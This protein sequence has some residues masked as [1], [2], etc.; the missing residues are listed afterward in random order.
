MLYTVWAILT[1]WL[2]GFSIVR[3]FLKRRYGYAALALGGGYL[4][5]FFV[6]ALAMHFYDSLAT[7]LDI[8]ALLLLAWVI[9]VALLIFAPAKRCSIE[10]LRLE[11]APPNWV[12]GVA[13]CLSL[14]LLYRWGLAL[15]DLLYDS[16]FMGLA[17][18]SAT[19]SSLTIAASP[20]VETRLEI[21]LWRFM[22]LILLSL[23]WSEQQISLIGSDFLGIGASVAVYLLVF[24]GLRYLGCQLLP[25]LLSA[26]ALVSFLSVGTEIEAS[27]AAMWAVLCLLLIV[28]GLAIVLIYG[29]WRV[30][31]LLS[32]VVP[33]SVQH[34][35]I[36]I[37]AVIP[38]MLLWRFFGAV[39][40]LLLFVI[41]CLLGYFFDAYNYAGLSWLESQ[42]ASYQLPLHAN[43]QEDN[44]Y[45]WGFLSAFSLFGLLFARQKNNTDFSVFIV[46]GLVITGACLLPFLLLPLSAQVMLG[47]S[48][49]LVSYALPVLVLLPVSVYHSITKDD[50]TLPPI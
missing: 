27:Y 36:A 45:Y 12:Y 20:P 28:F 49:Q 33:L 47:Y 50:E 48:S 25:S 1:P 18:Q 22:E 14:V 5:G 24:G 40:S 7:V 10:E 8:N 41:V 21:N 37:L 46:V 13:F 44:R 35:S 9:I 29:E 30:L 6:V 16:L 39:Y 23:P 17:E 11:K 19:T 34:V 42:F 3:G 43:I 15:T 31:L 32:V 4:V 38:I 26:Y 2:L